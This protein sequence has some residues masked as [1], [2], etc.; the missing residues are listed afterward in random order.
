MKEEQKYLEEL[1]EL[2]LFSELYQKFYDKIKF[3][4]SNIQK[5]AFEIIFY[6]TTEVCQK[7]LTDRSSH[8][9]NPTTDFISVEIHSLNISLKTELKEL[10]KLV[11]T[12]TEKISSDWFYLFVIISHR[13]RKKLT[14]KNKAQ[15][16]EEY[17]VQKYCEYYTIKNKQSRKEGG[18]KAG[19]KK[20]QKFEIMYKLWK[21]NKLYDENDDKYVYDELT[22]LY[23]KESKSDTVK[24]PVEYPTFKRTD[25]SGT[26]TKFTQRL[27]EEKD[28]SS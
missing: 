24:L 7:V 6:E 9:N 12:P 1:Q 23:R 22:K 5:K 18:K 11:N 26:L 3:S 13:L 15:V 10:E 8:F 14:Q 17:I 27:A 4:L 25:S 2:K 16:N 28:A 21:D 20:R 19:A